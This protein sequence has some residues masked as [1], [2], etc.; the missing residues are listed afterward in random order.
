M[1][2]IRGRRGVVEENIVGIIRR[3]AKVLTLTLETYSNS[4]DSFI[5][6]TKVVYMKNEKG[7]I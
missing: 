7:T 1:A 5:F 6:N 2:K 3:C 4:D